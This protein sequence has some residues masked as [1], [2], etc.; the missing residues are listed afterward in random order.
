[1]TSELILYPNTLQI[2]ND[3]GNVPSRLYIIIYKGS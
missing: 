3:K 2:N 1:M